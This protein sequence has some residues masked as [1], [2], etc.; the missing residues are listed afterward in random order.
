MGVWIETFYR[1]H[2]MLYFAV[3]PYMGCGLKSHSQ[4]YP[5]ML[6]A[7]KFGCSFLVIKV[8]LLVYLQKLNELC[9]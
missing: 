6:F 2:F 1:A 9:E 8:G 4:E 5:L 7:A 3:T